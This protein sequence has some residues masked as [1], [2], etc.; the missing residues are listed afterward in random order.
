MYTS[1]MEGQDM[2][3]RLRVLTDSVW[4]HMHGLTNKL[5]SVSSLQLKLIEYAVYNRSW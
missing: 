4:L 2:K 5:M 1:T 3:G